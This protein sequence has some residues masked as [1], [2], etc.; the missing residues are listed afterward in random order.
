MLRSAWRA[1]LF[2]A[3]MTCLCLV[4]LQPFTLNQM[5]HSADGLLQL[6]R[7]LALEHSLRVDHPLWPRFS[8][9]LVYGYG[10][11]LFNFFPP[12]A[13]Y[14]ASLAHQTGMSFLGA[15][16][17]SMSAFT[18][19]AGTG[20]F[21]LGRLW[22]KSALGGWVAAAAYVYS[23]YLLFDSVARGATAELAALAALPFAFYGITRLAFG[24]GRSDFLLALA[25]VSIFI[26]LHTIVTLHGAALLALYGV[27]LVWRAEESRSVLLRL[28]LGG[29]LAL[30]LT[31]FYWLPAL[32]ERD[33]I[34]LPLIAEQLGHIDV[35]RHLRSL[36]E[37]LA[38][39]QTADPTQ[40]NQALP[41]ALGWPQLILA[42]LGA[43]LSWRAPHRRYRSLM[44]ALW[45]VIGILLFLNTSPSAW[46]WRNIP[47]IGFTQFPWRLLG[48]ASLLLALMCGVGARLL[49]LSLGRRRVRLVTVSAVL[50]TVMLYALPWTYTLYRGDFEAG[51]IGDVQRFERQSGQLALSSYAEYLPVSADMGQLDANRLIERFEASD[52]IPRLLPSATLDILAQEWRGRSAT[53]RLQSA[54]AQTLV[55]DWLYVPGWTAVIDGE[56]VAVFPSTPAGL[57]ALEAPA[58]EFDLQ[59]SLAPTMTQSLANAL[60]GIG[61]AAAV[62]ALL[63]WSRLT[64][65]RSQRRSS[66]AGQGRWLLIVAAIGIALFLL[67][68]L[69]LDTADTPIKRSKFGYLRDVPALANFGNRI[70]LIAVEAPAEEF[71]GPTV[72][73]KL[74]WRLHGAPLE[75]DYSSIIRMRDPQGLV[76]AEASAFTPGGLATSNWLAGA[77][78]EDVIELEAPPF[79]PALPEPYSFDLSLFDNDSLKALSLINETGDPQD[80]K[81]LIGALRFRP[82]EADF[83]ARNVLPLP[84]DI[85]K[86]SALLVAAP[87]LPDS[88]TAG[89]TLQ[90]SWVWQK[91]RGSR[92]EATA[93]LLWLNE[94]GAV[95]AASAA[96][97]LVYGYDF[98]DWSVGEANRGHHQAVVPAKLPAGRYDLAIRPLDPSSQPLGDHYMLER[99]MT[100]RAPQREYEAPRFDFPSGR[101]WA[102][103]IVLHGFSLGAHG[104]VELIWGTDRTLSE[105]LR[106]FVHALDADALIAAQWDGVPVDWTRPT[107]GWVE[108]EFIRTSHAL[109]L[110]AGEYRLAVG[111]YR[112]A[113]GERISLDAADALELQ[114]L[115]VIE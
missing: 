26:P 59:L 81:F 5:P 63:L 85:R 67:K 76:V 60:S 57:L 107:T 43:L 113:S 109:A 105:S 40:Q 8:S 34:K 10:A 98:A 111:W 92:E 54:E 52:V 49:S 91:L 97:P 108:G 33:T 112:P 17:L 79:T 114:Q 71:A 56:P 24:G 55:F 38:L 100:V 16:L 104:Q 27:F 25:A 80:V 68:A 106:L 28:A 32:A 58:G 42:A 62:L 69:A 46:F 84:A 3:G 73:F 96:L 1:G 4:A 22:T 12:L 66:S 99:T 78:I 74:Y 88:A 37:M 89:D 19:L 41:I 82:S 110:P 65:E 20:M 45:L 90:F 31:A 102:N 23:P 14:P 103:G 6:H 64:T 15:W 83:E 61:L 47:L 77:Y 51:D 44:M 87:V 18:V 29:V 70:D 21:L 7:T 36:S 39:P 48:L 9:G 53:L 101:E 35:T 75:R 94:G 95:A 11:P 30:L 2:L 93:Q 13:Y 86:E 115:L 72:T 50:A